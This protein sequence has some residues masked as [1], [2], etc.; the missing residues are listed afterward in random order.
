MEERLT[1]EQD[2]ILRRFKE[3]TR[4]E[5]DE[6]CLAILRGNDWNL[7]LSANLYLA[8]INEQGGGRGEEGRLIPRRTTFG[9]FDALSLVIDVLTSFM[10][11]L[12]RLI[13]G[14]ITRTNFQVREILN[15]I[16]SIFCCD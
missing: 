1:D 4:A 12:A 5:N 8:E 6:I 9:L 16:H 13:G 14:Y 15:T 11:P 10:S 7:E 3:I 2:D